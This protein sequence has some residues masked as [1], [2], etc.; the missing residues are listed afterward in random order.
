MDFYSIQSDG[1]KNGK[2]T[3]FQKH[4]AANLVLDRTNVCHVSDCFRIAVINQNNKDLLFFFHR[5]SKREK[6]RMH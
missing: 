3:I 6:C 1:K 4:F 2:A 5:H